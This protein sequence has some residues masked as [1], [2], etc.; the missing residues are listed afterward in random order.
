MLVKKQLL[1]PS[2]NPD[3]HGINNKAGAI[4]L[5]KQHSKYVEPVNVD[6][7]QVITF[8]GKKIQESLSGFTLIY[9]TDTH[10]N[11]KKMPN[12]KTAVDMFRT[13]QSDSL[14]VHAG[15]FGMGQKKLNS[16]VDF[17]NK[18]GFDL[19]TLGNHEFIAGINSLT[20]AIKNSEFQTILAN[21]DIPESNPLSTLYKN[22]KIL[23]YVIKVLNGERYG[24]IGATTEDLNHFKKFLSGAKV[25]NTKEVIQK[26]VEELEKQGVKRIILLSHLGY[27]KDIEMSQ[28][29]GIDV[30]VGGHKHLAIPGIKKNINYFETTR[31]DGTKEPVLILHG[32]AHNRYVGVSHLVFN[33]NGI[34]QIKEDSGTIVSKFN[35]FV[36]KHLTPVW[37]RFFNNKTQTITDNKLYDLKE[38]AQDPE[39]KKIV[40]KEYANMHKIGHLNYRITTDWPIW[41]AT[42]TGSIIADA[43][44]N[45]TSI[46]IDS[47][48]PKTDIALVQ[49]G[50]FKRGLEKG[51][52][53]AEYIED[54]VVPFNPHIVK[55]QITGQAILDTLNHTAECVNKTEDI[56]VMQVSG[57][58]YTIDMSKPL[59][60][61]VSA[62]SVFV[63][64]NG[65]FVPLNLN[66]TY[67]AAYDKFLLSGQE[68]FKALK[69]VKVLKEYE[70]LSNAEAYIQYLKENMNNPDKLN[71]NLKE[72]I[73][74]KNMPR[75]PITLNSIYDWIGII[76][77]EK[78]IHCD[79]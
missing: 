56:G 52:L 22:G 75:K 47:F 3:S 4:E 51:P 20:D 28:I 1:A 37:E 39:I 67:I 27:N 6:L 9:T 78:I 13:G 66:K 69:N 44:K 36:K 55:V 31:P 25:L 2:Y 63:E 18:I 74:V 21:M 41:G 46:N 30:I 68:G 53:Y 14:L 61:R 40:D 76:R 7:K 42:Q 45:L 65:K 70:N 60:Q 34:L 8:V 59:N 16:Q 29:P 15:D 32:G 58:K 79:L 64:Q 23:P 50:C 49:A 72:R 33:N 19:A 38:F 48:L 26:R 10:R 54:F 71:I 17:L 62:K 5:K 57:L 73:M 77:R 43:V 11:I 24:F 12:L 35:T